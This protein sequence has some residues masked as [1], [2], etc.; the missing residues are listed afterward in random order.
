MFSYLKLSPFH[1]VILVDNQQELGAHRRCSCLSHPVTSQTLSRTP[2]PFSQGAFITVVLSPAALNRLKPLSVAPLSSP[3]LVSNILLLS[4]SPSFLPASWKEQKN[5]LGSSHAVGSGTPTGS[6]AFMCV[7]QCSG[8]VTAGCHAKKMG[9]G[10]FLSSLAPGKTGPTWPQ[11]ATDNEDP[12]HEF[13][14]P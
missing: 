9:K 1:K 13:H 6:L 2:P 8:G 14:L 5:H 11:P 3:Q 10:L 4:L 12:G 7:F